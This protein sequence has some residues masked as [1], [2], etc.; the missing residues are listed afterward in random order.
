MLFYRA[1]TRFAALAADH[2]IYAA[3]AAYTAYAAYG[4]HAATTAYNCICSI[5]QHML[6]ITA[7]DAY[8]SIC[9][10]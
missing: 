9:S 6:H 2:P 7:D 10:I 5:Y 1:P 8:Y 4:T 3:Y